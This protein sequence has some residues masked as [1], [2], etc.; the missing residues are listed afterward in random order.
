MLISTKGRYA[1]RLLDIASHPADEFVK[2]KDVAARQGIS[3][4]YLESIVKV[5]VKGGILTGAR[6]SRGGYRLA[7]EADQ[8]TAWQVL[9]NTEGSLAAVS[10]QKDGAEP[11]LRRADCPSTPLWLG[12]DRLIYDY[13][14]GYSVADLGRLEM[15]T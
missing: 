12:L 4:K 8:I 15:P 14:S 5:L 3:E 10:C 6:G 13:L 1:L 2:L 11:C 9:L 7:R